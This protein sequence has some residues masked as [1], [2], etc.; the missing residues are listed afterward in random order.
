MLFFSALS[1]ECYGCTS[2]TSWDDC[3]R[4][5]TRCAPSEDQCIKLHLM[6]GG[7]NHYFKGCSPKAAC[8]KKNNPIC[9]EASGSHSVTCDIFCC[10]G[11]N[12]NAGSAFV[13]SGL[14]LLACAVVSLMILLKAWNWSINKHS[15]N[16]Q[17][18]TNTLVSLPFF[19]IYGNLIL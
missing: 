9:K 15:L 7:V 8:Q 12:C 16:G 4:S 1:L 10:E 2:T 5:A 19:T 14:L 3:K 13:A 11:D 6:A 17:K 18:K